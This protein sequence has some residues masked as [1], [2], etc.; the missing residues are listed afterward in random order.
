MK[1]SYNIV[2]LL[3]LI[4]SLNS[5]THALSRRKQ[6][7][8]GKTSTL[9]ISP[10]LE[11]RKLFSG[12]SYQFS[13]E[14][15]KN[16]PLNIYGSGGMILYRPGDGKINKIPHRSLA[17]SMRNSAIYLNNNRVKSMLVIY[18]SHGSFSCNG[19]SSSG[20]I[21]LQ[22]ES[23]SAAVVIHA[24]QNKMKDR[25]KKLFKATND[26]YRKTMTHAYS[27][28]SEQKKAFAP[29]KLIRILLGDMTGATTTSW[30]LNSHHGFTVQSKGQTSTIKEK[31]LFIRRKH[32]VTYVNGKPYGN[33]PVICMPRDGVIDFVGKQY[34]GNFIVHND[35]ERLYLINEL[36]IEDY[37]YSVLKT[38]SWPGW[39]LE[40]NKVQAVA[41]RSYVLSMIQDAEKSNRPYHVTNTN[42]HQTYSGVHE[43]SVIKQAVKETRHQILTYNGVVARTMFDVCCG[44][45][46]PRDISTMN[47]DK[48]PYLARSYSCTHCKRCKVYSWQTELE[49]KQLERL[50]GVRNLKEVKILK[51][52]KAGLPEE[53]LFKGNKSVTITGKKIYSLIPG[54]RSFCFSTKKKSGKILFEGRG[55]GHH[56]G[57]CQWGAREMVRDG[58]NYKKILSFFYPKTTLTTL[59]RK[60]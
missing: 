8:L 12:S 49:L 60:G 13:Q 52:D 55:Y 42:L 54:V 25:G 7:K 21:L 34:Q 6:G 43:S 17:I 59:K 19:I 58:W 48:D 30:Q 22:P 53:V 10:Q 40:V 29:T 39:P 20:P 35:A 23:K 18:S 51:K 15:I 38:E 11:K 31:Q 24:K 56:V 45:V 4:F 28:I 3:V 2:S 50:V 27:N 46:K 14:K 47:F 37:I 57:L 36:D 26:E 32:G 16:K 1:L 44:G 41:S 9:K 5:F 33:A